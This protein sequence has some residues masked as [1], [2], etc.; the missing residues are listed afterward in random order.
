M[1]SPFII[2]PANS[3]ITCLPS[4]TNW[5][6]SRLQQTTNSNATNTQSS[7][8]ASGSWNNN[9][10]SQGPA[11]QPSNGNTNYTTNQTNTQQQFTASITTQPQQQNTSS[12]PQQ[13]VQQSYEQQ[14]LQNNQNAMAAQGGGDQEKKPSAEWVFGKALFPR[15]D[16]TCSLC[17][18]YAS[19]EEVAGVKKPGVAYWK[20]LACP[21]KQ[22]NG[23]GKMGNEHPIAG[24]KTPTAAQQQ[25]QSVPQQ[26]NL[27]GG[28]QGAVPAASLD[29][30]SMMM[31]SLETWFKCCAEEM[32]MQ[33]NMLIDIKGDIDLLGQDLCHMNNSIG[34]ISTQ[35]LTT[36][37][38]Y[39]KIIKSSALRPA[40]KTTP[41]P[42]NKRQR[43][44]APSP[45]SLNPSDE[46]GATQT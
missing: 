18:S 43:K 22:N 9:S 2:P 4:Q 8:N 11:I 40:E 7:G 21:N 12:Y 34:E 20:C 23:K 16:G 35:L 44:T 5:R 14:Q 19:I 29:V 24:Y 10:S 38:Q 39:E 15:Q 13:Q 1:S 25:P 17:G 33:R 45:P 30:A 37:E 32:S 41:L 36:H 46:E 3:V 26:Q 31:E 28:N 27:G 42:P 6:T